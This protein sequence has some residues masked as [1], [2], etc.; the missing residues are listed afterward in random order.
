MDVVEGKAE[1]QLL[2]GFEL[3][4]SVKFAPIELLTTFVSTGSGMQT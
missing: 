4:N 1:R 3:L 2:R